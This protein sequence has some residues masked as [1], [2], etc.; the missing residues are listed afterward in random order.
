MP[1]AYLAAHATVA[2]LVR[3]RTCGARNGELRSGFSATPV[4]ARTVRDLPGYGA[5]LLRRAVVVH[6]AGCA[7]PFA[8]YW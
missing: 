5:V 7:V 1:L 8:R 2:P 6:P 3:A 4:F